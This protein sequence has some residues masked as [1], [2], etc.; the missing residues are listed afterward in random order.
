[1]PT[2]W[3][4][5]RNDKRVVSKT[6]YVFRGDGIDED[7]IEKAREL[8]VVSKSHDPVK[9]QEL[10]DAG[11]IKG[12]TE[13]DSGG[14]ATALIHCIRSFGHYFFFLSIPVMRDQIDLKWYGFFWRMGQ[15]HLKIPHVGVK[16]FY[17][18]PLKSATL[19]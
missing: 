17:T 4:R 19:T 9:L 5:R 18:K 10:A 3:S 7:W 15:T 1:M 13:Y 6:G 12:Y 16:G 14:G 11:L 2:D 8:G